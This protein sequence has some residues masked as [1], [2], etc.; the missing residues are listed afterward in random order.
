M[1]SERLSTP[2]KR[3]FATTLRRQAAH[4]SRPC[5]NRFGVRFAC[6]WRTSG[7]IMMLTSSSARS[8]SCACWRRDAGKRPRGPTMKLIELTP[9]LALEQVIQ[10]AKHEDIVLTRQGH[11][12][13]LVSEIDDDELYWRTRERDGEFLASLARARA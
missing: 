7:C 12:V 11:A 13:A 4:A 6:G 5:G 2:S 8:A 10:Q 9:D 3:T 1:T